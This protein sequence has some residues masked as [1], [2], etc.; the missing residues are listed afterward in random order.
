MKSIETLRRLGAF[1]ELQKT[2]IEYAKSLFES[3]NLIE[4][5]MIAKTVAFDTW[6]NDYKEL[7]VKAYLLLGDI[8]MKQEQKYGYYL[9]ALK[10]SEFNPKIYIR[11]CFILIFR[12]K[13]M[14]RQLQ[15]KFINSLKEA[16]KDRDKYFDQFLEALNAK[17]E[18]K[19]YNISE[20]PKS[21]K[22]EFD[23]F[24]AG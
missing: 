17:L 1:F 23:S 6:H 4:A 10:A 9:D 13:N 7:S 8:V 16:N 12:M 15:L 19:K 18:G 5:E 14:E 21:L 2:L 24:K 22:Q 3:D 20:L 11:T